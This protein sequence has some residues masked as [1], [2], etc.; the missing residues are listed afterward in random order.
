MER[1]RWL[2]Q[3]P[4]TT[5]EA[6]LAL[7][8]NWSLESCLLPCLASSSNLRRMLSTCSFKMQWHFPPFSS[9]RN[10][11]MI[12]EFPPSPK[13]NDSPPPPPSSVVLLSFKVLHYELDWEK[14]SSESWAWAVRQPSS[15]SN[16]NFEDNN[17]KRNSKVKMIIILIIHVNCP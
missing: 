6:P 5:L 14:H 7:G 8:S 11:K 10:A 17:S 3:H 15:K 16:W 2:P 9:I 13:K 1:Y 4:E 12:L